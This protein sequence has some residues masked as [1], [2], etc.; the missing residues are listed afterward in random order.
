MGS[1]LERFKLQTLTSVYNRDGLSKGIDEETVKKAKERKI[2][3]AQHTWSKVS[4]PAEKSNSLQENNASNISSQTQ[5]QEGMMEVAHLSMCGSCA[6]HVRIMCGS[7]RAAPCAV[8]SGGSV[9]SESS[10]QR[11]GLMG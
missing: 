10:L 5:T 6:D 3:F 9:V 8:R 2:L 4:K 7:C 1:V 11:S